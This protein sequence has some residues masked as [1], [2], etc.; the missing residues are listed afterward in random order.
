MKEV[1]KFILNLFVI[2]TMFVIA[3]SI[4]FA[5]IIVMKSIYDLLMDSIFATFVCLFI[6]GT[7]IYLCVITFVD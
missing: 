5:V 6:I 7:F 3:I 4:L 2:L 1:I